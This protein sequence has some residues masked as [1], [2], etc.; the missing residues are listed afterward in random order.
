MFPL[1]LTAV[2]LL[3]NAFFVSIEFAMI[4][5]RKDRL[6]PLVAQGNRRAEKL[7]YSMQ[8]LSKMLAGAQLGITIASLLLGKVGEPAIAHLLEIPAAWVGLPHYLLHP[9]SFVIALLLV[10]GLHI[11]LGEMVPKNI[12]LAGPETV[13]M[14]LVTPHIWFVKIT[15][16]VIWVMNHLA[17]FTLR[18]FGIEQKDELSSSVDSSQLAS[19]FNESVSEGLLDQEEHTRLRAALRSDT[20][21]IAGITIPMAEV[22]T[23]TLAGLTLSTVDD[24]VADTGFSRFPVVDHTG[25]PV[26]YLHI[27][28]LLAEM[29]PATPKPGGR[30]LGREKLRPLYTVDADAMLDDTLRFMRRRQAHLVQVRRAGELVGFVWLE[31]IIEEYVGTVRDWTHETDPDHDLITPS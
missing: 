1:I 2:L 8:H 15:S 9:V 6:D 21:T 14:I 31:D 12:A 5:S 30:Q 3:I 4:S 18:L 27:K 24:A 22:R 28:D 13:G 26:G 23:L 25:S 20:Q 11:I 17:G 10:T 7:L 29:V 16:P 19:M